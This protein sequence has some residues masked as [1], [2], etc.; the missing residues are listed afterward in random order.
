MF[1]IGEYVVNATNGICQITEVTEM[2]LM[3]DKKM[4]LYYLLVPI[5][6]QS[7]R[8]YVPVDTAEARIRRTITRDE[9]VGILERVDE[10]AEL[11]IGNEKEREG[12]Y[13]EAV[14]SCDPELLVS[15]LKTLYMRMQSR[16]IQGKKST[17]I[18]ERYYKLAE[19]RLYSELAFALEMPRSEMEEIIRDRMELQYHA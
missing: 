1:N 7:A 10:I 4:K 17:A 19:T 5:E 13:K 12:R 15:L 16:M 6:E 14:K 11:Q 18:D 3:G 2:D 9:A 8:V